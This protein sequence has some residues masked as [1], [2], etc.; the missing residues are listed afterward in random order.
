MTQSN[1]SP[2]MPL[3]GSWEVRGGWVVEALVRD[4]AL[5][6]DQACGLVGNLGYES[7]CFTALQEEAPMVRG[8]RGGYGWAQWTGARRINFE[9]WCATHVLAP[10]SDEANYGFLLHEL[11]GAYKGFAGR[12]RRT[13]GIE[14]ATRLTHKEYE[15]PSDVL[16]G[17]YRSGPDR[18]DLALR[19]QVPKDSTLV[20]LGDPVELIKAAQ[21]LIGA[22]PDG[23][24]GPETRR[25]LRVWVNS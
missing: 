4:A 14:E 20:D 19:L 16:D 11:L 2:L 23:I 13:T 25:L 12:L 22:E 15:T 3:E 1:T 21:R 9:N 7:R 24:P 5:T 18:L 6:H 10:A 17:S 8:S